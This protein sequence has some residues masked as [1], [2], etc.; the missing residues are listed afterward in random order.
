MVSTLKNNISTPEDSKLSASLLLGK[1]NEPP[2]L[3]LPGEFKD[4][5]CDLQAR[6]DWYQR[7]FDFIS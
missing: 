5:K 1:R 6:H 4:A 2:Q 7:Q 3:P